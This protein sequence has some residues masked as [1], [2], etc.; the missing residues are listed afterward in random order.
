MAPKNDKPFTFTLPK[1]LEGKFSIIR[2]LGQGAYG[3]V[4]YV[5]HLIFKFSDKSFQ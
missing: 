4:W 3:V 2:E 5:F 1:G